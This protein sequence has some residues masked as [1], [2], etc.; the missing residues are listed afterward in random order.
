MT[1]YTLAQLA[2]VST[3]T[4]SRVINGLPGVGESTRIKVK[5]LIDDTG[6]IP[7]LIA[8]DLSTQKSLTA[9]LVLPGINSYFSPAVQSISQ[10]FRDAGVH[11]LIT[12]NPGGV[13]DDLHESEGLQLLLSKRVQGVIM[14]LSRITPRHAEVLEKWPENVELVLINDEFPGSRFNTLFQ[15]PEPGYRALFKHLQARGLLNLGY[16]GGPEGD[17]TA[18]RRLE[19]IQK[20]GREMGFHLPAELI[21]HGGFDLVGGEQGV[22]TLLARGKFQALLCANDF[23]AIGAMRALRSRGISVPEQVA[24][25]G[26]DDLEISRYTVPALTTITQDVARLGSEAARILLRRW[27]KPEE[28]AQKI[29]FAS[30]LLQRESC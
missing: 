30:R 11:L 15:D 8:R 24:V 20:L 19:V 13:F 22:D 16:I 18:S 26:Y 21:T 1:I 3:A 2:G 28:P 27:E 17:R 9:G 25:V 5:K 7:N 29:F 6:Y 14:F 10:S 23:T 4:V 12:T